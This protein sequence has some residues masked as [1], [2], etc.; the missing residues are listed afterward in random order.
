MGPITRYLGPDIPKGPLKLWQDPVPDATYQ[1]IDSNDIASLKSEIMN[2]QGLNISVSRR[3]AVNTRN[4]VKL[5][6]ANVRHT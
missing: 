3:R 5:D 1:M 2:T 6:C 4:P